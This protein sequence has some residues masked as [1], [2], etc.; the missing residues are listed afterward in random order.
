[1][2]TTLSN[3]LP[4]KEVAPRLAISLASLRRWRVEGR[5]PRYL[6]LGASVRYRVSDVEQWLAS[7]PAGGD[8]VSRDGAA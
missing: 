1:M 4:E 5:G 3:L 8:G 6:K 2:I 7:R